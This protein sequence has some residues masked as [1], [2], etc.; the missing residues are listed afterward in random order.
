[1]SNSKQ[2]S[3]YSIAVPAGIA[4]EACYGASAFGKDI[5][6]NIY[7]NTDGRWT[8]SIFLIDENDNPEEVF[9]KGRKIFNS[10]FEA[11]ALGS[12]RGLEYLESFK[13]EE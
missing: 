10:F 1:M 2:V 8:Y 6:L 12:R 9:F 13:A 4:N 3:L 11:H 5:V 7:K